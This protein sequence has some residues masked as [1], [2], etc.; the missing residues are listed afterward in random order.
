MGPAAVEL[1][2]SLLSSSSV[3]ADD[4]LIV[5]FIDFLTYLLSTKRNVDLATSYLGLLLKVS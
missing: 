4:D 3:N 1:E 5:N 2:L